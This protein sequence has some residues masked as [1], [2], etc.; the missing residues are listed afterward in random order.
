MIDWTKRQKDKRTNEQRDKETKEQRGKWAKGQ[1][2][3]GTKGKS[4]TE[5]KQ[6]EVRLRSGD[7]LVA[8]FSLEVEAGLKKDSQRRGLGHEV[9]WELCSLRRSKLD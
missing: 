5:G 8:M 6:A 9:P 4:W 3:K 7:P 1:R 2:K